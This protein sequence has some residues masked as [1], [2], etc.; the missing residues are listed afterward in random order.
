MS[1]ILRVGSKTLYRW[2]REI[3]SDYTPVEQSELGP[4]DVMENGKRVR[5][6]IFKIEHMGTHMAID[7]KNLG[8][9][10]YTILS[11]NDTGKIAAM[12]ESHK[13]ETLT[14]ILRKFGDKCFKVRT[15][16]RDLSQVYE[17]T[18]REVFMNAAHVADKFHVVKIGLSS[19]QQIRIEERQ[20][21][22]KAK[23][24]RHKQYMDEQNRMVEEGLQNRVKPFKD[25]QAVL[26]N[27]ET[28]LQLLARSRYLLFK[29][30]SQWSDHQSARAKILFELYPTLVEAYEV[31]CAFRKWYQKSKQFTPIGVKVWRLKRWCEKCSSCS[32]DHMLEFVNV[33]KRHQ[34]S[35]IRFFRTS[36]TNA[37]AEALN[38]KI[39]RFY[40]SSYGTRDIDFFLFR[41]ARYFS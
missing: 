11:N 14:N 13:K 30:S 32:S 31:I 38:G 26:A 22:L 28:K 36:I 4:H 21:E 24:I 20:K 23:R 10:T 19:L 33:V 29:F 3:L 40:S 9:Q 1:R 6:P 37:K 17:W 12:I 15:I 8:G 41:L 25:D 16:S 5:V 2:Y 7:E 35:I 27:G 18:C 34:S 39:A